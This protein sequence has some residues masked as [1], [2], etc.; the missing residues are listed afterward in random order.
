MAEFY[1]EDKHGNQYTVSVTKSKT[2]LTAFI[3]WKNSIIGQIQCVIEQSNVLEI[4]NIEI[5]EDPILP[6]NGL[7]SRRPFQRPHRNFR[8]LGLGTAMLKFVI[9][10]AERLGLS[11][12]CGFIT[13]EDAQKTA[14][15]L[16]WYQKHGFIIADDEEYLPDETVNICRVVHR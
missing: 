14:Y 15:L 9:N 5:F 13:P 10:Q 1:V 12:I 2:A 3:I 11:K 6:R 8:Q 4:G 7:F 16:D